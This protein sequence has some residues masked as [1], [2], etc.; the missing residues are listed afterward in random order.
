MLCPC[1]SLSSPR[2]KAWDKDRGTGSLNSAGRQC[3]RKGE[4]ANKELV[5][6]LVADGVSLQETGGDG[7]LPSALS[8]I[9]VEGMAASGALNP[10]QS[11]L[12]DWA[13]SQ[14]LEK[15]KADKLQDTTG[16]WGRNCPM[17]VSV[18]G[19]GQR[20]VARG[21]NSIGYPPPRLPITSP[22]TQIT[23]YPYQSTSP[24]ISGFHQSLPSTQPLHSAKSTFYPSAI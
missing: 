14:E 23:S 6:E 12:L 22:P 18:A 21:T 8:A 4:K 19:E 5:G 15:H 1:F 9:L 17:V 16:V 7:H 3:D 2:S 13:S 10:T 11:L 20:E 24:G